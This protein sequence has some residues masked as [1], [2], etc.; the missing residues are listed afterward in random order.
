MFTYIQNVCDISLR[1]MEDEFEYSVNYFNGQR[2]ENGNQ[3]EINTYPKKVLD[4]EVKFDFTENDLTKLKSLLKS[5]NHELKRENIKFSAIL[6]LHNENVI[7]NDIGDHRYYGFLRLI[8]TDTF[9][10]TIMEDI[11]IVNCIFE[12]LEDKVLMCIKNYIKNIQYKNLSKSKISFSSIPIILSPQASG[13]FAHEILGH[14][15]EEDFYGFY[16]GNY[17][18]LKASE[19][20]TIHDSIENYTDIIG[21]NKY[22]DLGIPIKP[23]DLLEKGKLV[24]ILSTSIDKSFDKKLYGVSRRENYR[25]SVIPRMRGTFILPHDNMNQ[26]DIL[27]QYINAIFLNK[28]YLGGVDPSSGIY[29]LTGDGFYVKNG[30]KK[31]FIGNLKLT[32]NIKKDLLSVDYVGNDFKMFGSYCIKLDQTVRVGMGGPTISLHNMVVEGDVYGNL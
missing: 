20:L 31:N 30:E 25:Q 4:I 23:L 13:Y 15:L 14:L 21:L 3:V 8:L 26:T 5:I 32:G 18:D 7:I 6:N 11:P 17:N 22:D 24:N 28:S 16:K 9:N 19:K 29:T 2:R 27:N 1:Y 12:E 10:N